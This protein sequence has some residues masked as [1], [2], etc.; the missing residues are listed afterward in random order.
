[1]SF[2]FIHKEN[3]SLLLDDIA[4]KYPSKTDHAS[5]LKWAQKPHWKCWKGGDSDHIPRLDNDTMY[6]LTWMEIFNQPSSLE[7]NLNV[8]LWMILLMSLNHYVDG[9]LSNV[10]IFQSSITHPNLL[11]I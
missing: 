2:G 5:L 7:K 11:V 8:L 10:S 6:G 3:V 1:M 9:C 4:T